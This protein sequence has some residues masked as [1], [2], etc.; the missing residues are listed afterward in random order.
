MLVLSRHHGSRLIQPSRRRRQRLPSKMRIWLARLTSVGLAGCTAPLPLSG[1]ASELSCIPGTFVGDDRGGAYDVV[2]SLTIRGWCVVRSAPSRYPSKRRNQVCGP[3]S[4]RAGS[5]PV[6]VLA[7]HFPCSTSRSVHL[8]PCG[9]GNGATMMLNRS[10]MKG[11]NSSWFSATPHRGLGRHRG[12]RWLNTVA[13]TS[14]DTR[15]REPTTM[16]VNGCRSSRQGRR[17]VRLTPR[18]TLV[19]KQIHS[20]QSSAFLANTSMSCSVSAGTRDIGATRN[21]VAVRWHFRLHRR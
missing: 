13:S 1:S 15:L 8:R 6:V 12:H 17:A 18:H 14:V 5:G 10:A 11:V 3:S 7:D 16:I 2:C 4:T 19:R 9:D 21:P 20:L